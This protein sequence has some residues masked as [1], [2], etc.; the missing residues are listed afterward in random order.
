MNMT[1]V[2]RNIILHGPVSD[3]KTA[4]STKRMLVCIFMS[5]IMRFNGD[6]TEEWGYWAITVGFYSAI[7]RFKT[8][9]KQHCGDH[10]PLHCEDVVTVR[11]I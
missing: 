4:R 8:H 6:I 2:H 7:Y 9:S 1:M 10:N 11:I 3:Q 5:V